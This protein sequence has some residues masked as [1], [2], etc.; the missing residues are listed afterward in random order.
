[1]STKEIV[2]ELL[3]RLPGDVSLQD[4]A[5]KI[6]FIAAVREDLKLSER[7]GGVSIGEASSCVFP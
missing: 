2:S 3:E 5:R 7:A 1:M 4:A 6:E